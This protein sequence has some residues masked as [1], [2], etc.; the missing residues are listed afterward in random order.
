MSHFTTIQTQLA[1]LQYITEALS[2]LDM[3][4][5]VGSMEIRGYGGAR[6]AVEIKVPTSNP[7]Y[8]M[9]FRKQGE[10]Y[11]L[12]ADW[13]GIKDVNQDE[14]LRQVTQR[15]AYHAAKNQLEEQDFTIVDE[16][17]EQDETI[18]ITVRRMV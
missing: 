11:E 16:D 8:D 12:V 10:N 6:T 5:E 7:D 1:V 13:W 9:G 18:H 15:Y 2:D 3:R 14:F 17:V 4:H